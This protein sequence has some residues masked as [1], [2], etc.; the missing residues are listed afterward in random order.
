M[1][2]RNRQTEKVQNVVQKAVAIPPTK[3]IRFV[4]TKAGILPNLSAIHP[5]TSPPSMA[6][7]KNIDC[8]V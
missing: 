3:P 5:K 6:P 4:P 1:P 7:Q 8:A 2:T